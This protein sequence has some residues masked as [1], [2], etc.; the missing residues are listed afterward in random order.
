MLEVQFTQIILSKFKWVGNEYELGFIGEMEAPDSGSTIVQK[1]HLHFSVGLNVS[2]GILLIRNPYKAIVSFVQ[3]L[4][5]GHLGQASVHTFR[6]KGED[7]ILK[8]KER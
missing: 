4:E 2:K 7:Y 8:L 6:K 3:Y 1:M 5:S